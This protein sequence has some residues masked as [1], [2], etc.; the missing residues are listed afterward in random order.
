[1]D[2]LL[3]ENRTDLPLSVLPLRCLLENVYLA[4]LSSFDNDGMCCV[5]KKEKGEDKMVQLLRIYIKSTLSNSPIT[6]FGYA[7]QRNA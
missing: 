1:M 2:S 6:M 3:V 4:D 5:G 7:A